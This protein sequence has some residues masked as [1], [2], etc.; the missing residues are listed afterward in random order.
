MDFKKAEQKLKNFDWRSLKKFTS[1]QATEDLNAFLEKLPHNTNKTILLVAACIWGGAAALGLFTTL[2]LQQ[3]T[4]IRN[5]IQEA[6]AL[7]PNVPTIANVAID[8]NEVREFID[9]ISPIYRGLEIKASGA[10]VLVTAK[11]TAAF[12]QFREAIGHIQNGGSGWRV[13]IDT[14]CVGRECQKSPLSASLKI[15]KVSV[16]QSG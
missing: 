16:S 13:N 9:K 11:S 14:M 6:Q 15:N 5:E 7:K 8:A 10:S 1:A 4:E 2:Q 12:G 3:L